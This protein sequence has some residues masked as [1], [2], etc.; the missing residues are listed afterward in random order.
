LTLAAIRQGFCDRIP[1]QNLQGLYDS[2][3]ALD[4]PSP[5]QRCLKQW[6]AARQIARRAGLLVP[7]SRANSYVF[8]HQHF[9]DYFA[10][11]ALARRLRRAA[12]LD[13]FEDELY[14][15]LCQRRC[16]GAVTHAI[17]ILG[18]EPGGEPLVHHALDLVH[19]LDASDL[20]EFWAA[21]TPTV[22]CQWLEGKLKSCSYEEGPGA[23]DASVARGL[24]CLGGPARPDWQ[25]F[26]GAL[27]QLATP[28]AHALLLALARN[29]AIPR[30]CRIRAA[31]ALNRDRATSSKP[32]LSVLEDWIAKRRADPELGR[33]AL[34]L[35][36]RVAG[37]EAMR[38][39]Q[40]ICFDPSESPETRA[41]A[42][43]QLSHIENAVSDRELGALAR[44]TAQPVP[45]RSAAIYALGQRP[46]AEPLD[47]LADVVLDRAKDRE[48]RWRAVAVVHSRRI[49]SAVPA[50][51][52]LVQQR[53]EDESLRSYALTAACVLAPQTSLPALKRLLFDKHESATLR[54]GA[55]QRLLQTPGSVEGPALA[56]LCSDALEPPDVRIAAV[57]AFFKIDRVTAAVMAPVLSR[58]PIVGKV[59]AANEER[60]VRPPRDGMEIIGPEKVLTDVQRGDSEREM[61]MQK[62]IATRSTHAINLVRTVARDHNENIH[63]RCEAAVQ[64]SRADPLSAG[65]ILLNIYTQWQSDRPSPTV[66]RAMGRARAQQAVP[67]LE[68]AYRA[69]KGDVF[70]MTQAALALAWIRDRS[71]I[72]ILVE[73]CTKSTGLEKDVAREL[74]KLA[75]ET[76]EN[77][78]AICREAARCDLDHRWLKGVAASALRRVAPSHI[79]FELE[80]QHYRRRVLMGLSRSPLAREE[81]IQPIDGTSAALLAN[82]LP[83]KEDVVQQCKQAPFAIG[84]EAQAQ[85]RQLEQEYIMMAFLQHWRA[86]G[87]RPSLREAEE[88]A[89]AKGYRTSKS[90]LQKTATYQRFR[91]TFG[92]KRELR[93]EKSSGSKPRAV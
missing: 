58:D 5:W 32:L 61:A 79:E 53:D 52:S 84:R 43:E 76:D 33:E 81:C 77:W 6:T 34:R 57:Q 19:S 65:E 13:V 10:G 91:Q 21:T 31:H 50:L 47:W 12:Q 78:R 27:E 20:E 89:K 37:G 41:I 15:Y 4:E 45:L 55:L 72:P 36:V 49:A 51:L 64:L 28:H 30:R 17:A 88:W 38:L 62:L 29:P 87:G 22:A 2:L 46:T 14:G 23:D 60:Y 93:E 75:T 9:A 63:M 24:A 1:V 56:E 26:I 35:A 11:R 44:D 73:F 48:M 59:V 85:H 83:K 90:S 42:L 16:D 3:D 69:H 74:A 54:L 82:S 8:I 68:S 71:S 25:L 86:S 80:R 70:V 40:P 67:L 7:E 66:I 92:S 39:L 18:T